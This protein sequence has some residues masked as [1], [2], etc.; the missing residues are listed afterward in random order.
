MNYDFQIQELLEHLDIADIQQFCR[1]NKQFANFCRSSVGHSIIKRKYLQSQAETILQYLAQDYQTL[2]YMLRD[3]ATT[4][5]SQQETPIYYNLY[6]EFYLNKVVK[7][8]EQNPHMLNKSLNYYQNP[9]IDKF[10]FDPQDSNASEI[11]SYP[12]TRY[13]LKINELIN[14]SM[15]AEGDLFPWLI[16]ELGFNDLFPKID[17]K[18]NLEFLVQY[19]E[20]MKILLL[21][22]Q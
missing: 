5:R 1:T 19:P 22:W 15:R 3:Y 17:R 18:I 11:I 6:L 21:T 2:D 7:L 4:Q 8:L 10:D 12:E 9:L 13:E 16:L 20:L 14:L